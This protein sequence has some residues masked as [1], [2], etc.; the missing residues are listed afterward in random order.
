MLKKI[1]DQFDQFRHPALSS[2]PVLLGAM[3]E[4]LGLPG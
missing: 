4:S 2:R 1:I 3:A